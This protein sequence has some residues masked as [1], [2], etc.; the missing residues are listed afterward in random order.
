[1]LRE[2]IDFVVVCLL[3]IGANLYDALN[4]VVAFL[5]HMACLDFV[6]MTWQTVVILKICVHVQQVV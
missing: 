4:N 3:L 6:Y 2:V 5:F 1:M